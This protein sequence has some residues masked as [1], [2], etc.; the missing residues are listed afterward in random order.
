M[1]LQWVWGLLQPGFVRWAPPASQNHFNHCNNRL[2][3]ASHM[4]PRLQKKSTKFINNFWV[5]PPTD[6]QTDRHRQIKH[7]IL[8]GCN[9]SNSSS[10]LICTST[11]FNKSELLTIHR[12]FRCINSLLFQITARTVYTEKKLWRP[13]FVARGLHNVQQHSALATWIISVWWSC[14][15]DEDIYLL[16][17][18]LQSVRNL[19]MSVQIIFLNVV[20]S[21]Q[22]KAY[23]SSQK[24]NLIST[25]GHQGV[26]DYSTQR[27]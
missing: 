21:C 13:V 27:K 9:N 26:N 10:N 20:K 7:N 23:S 6:R 4:F 5:I 17:V 19:R 16:V 22:P 25:G 18:F 1:G 14:I 3:L 15:N 11:T 8:G 2:L 12:Q 24:T